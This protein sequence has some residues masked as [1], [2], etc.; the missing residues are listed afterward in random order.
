MTKSTDH[1]KLNTTKV[2]PSV[3]HPRIS[4]SHNF[5]TSG[6]DE[7]IGMQ[8][9]TPVD[10]IRKIREEH[11]ARHDFDLNRI[12]E[13]IKAHGEHLRFKGW[14]VIHKKKEPNKPQSLSC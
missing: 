11:A 5:F 3:H 14:N 9:L 13:D 8:I 2:K 4:L 7:K 6:S 12:F 10:E 1:P